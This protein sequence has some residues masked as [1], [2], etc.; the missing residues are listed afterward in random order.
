MRVIAPLFVAIMIAMT[1]VTGATSIS[2]PDNF[3]FPRVT[4]QAAWLPAAGFTIGNTSSL[5]GGSNNFMIG[6]TLG[7]GGDF[8]GQ[9]RMTSFNIPT[10][11]IGTNNQQTTGMLN[12]F[13]V[14]YK[15]DKHVAV[16]AGAT[17]TVGKLLNTDNNTEQSSNNIG[18]QIGGMLDVSV[19][20]G[21]SA[22]ADYSI[23]SQ[24]AQFAIGLEYRYIDIATL[25]LAYYNIQQYS[26]SYSGG[27]TSY[28]LQGPALGM[29]LDL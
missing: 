23:G 12:E 6:G 20:R 18:V 28:T 29:S 27:N 2:V 19:Y 15:I 8:A 1:S 3:A 7:F 16:Y 17:Y 9:Y 25:N 24:I 10:Q 5:T 11:K 4:L 21:L 13:N 26:L 22:F 14:L